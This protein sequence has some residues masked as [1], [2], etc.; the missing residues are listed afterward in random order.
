MNIMIRIINGFGILLIV[1][2]LSVLMIGLLVCA[3]IAFVAGLL[4]TFGMVS[5]QMNLGTGLEIPQIFSLPVGIVFGILFLGFA[6][7]C[8]KVLK[9]YLS[10]IRG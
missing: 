3:V 1:P 10:F 2:T 4:R 6:F 7:G 8:W 9:M 5:I